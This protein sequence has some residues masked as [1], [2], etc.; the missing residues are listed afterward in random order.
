M[1]AFAALAM[2]GIFGSFPRERVWGRSRVPCAWHWLTSAFDA[3][4]LLAGPR[5]DRGGRR[6]LNVAGRWSAQ[7]CMSTRSVTA[8]KLA[9]R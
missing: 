9:V 1:D 8:I 4:A 6:A 7:G 3:A 2:T 5:I